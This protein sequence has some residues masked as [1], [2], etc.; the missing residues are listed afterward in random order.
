[1]HAKQQTN[2]TQTNEKPKSQRS[3][4]KLDK[5][6]NS[7]GNQPQ[8]KPNDSDKLSEEQTW[9]GKSTEFNG[10][11]IEIPENMLSSEYQDSSPSD[12]RLL[13]GQSN[14]VSQGWDSSGHPS[15]HWQSQAWP[16]ANAHPGLVQHPS[17]FMSPVNFLPISQGQPPVYPSHPPVHPSYAQEQYP[18]HPGHQG[19]QYS[20]YYPQQQYPSKPNQQYPSPSPPLGGSVGGLLSTLAHFVGK[21][22]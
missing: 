7:S 11:Y 22:F 6:V 12:G 10:H 17:N 2:S 4:E 8:T 1:M 13:N 14:G 3:N 5:P 9:D 18:Q 20:Q 15:G 21:L 19:Q 16:P